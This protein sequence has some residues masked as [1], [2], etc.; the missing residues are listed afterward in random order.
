MSRKKCI[1]Y[2]LICVILIFFTN[3]IQENYFTKRNVSIPFSEINKT[4]TKLNTAC[5][6]P[7][8][9]NI[10][11]HLTDTDSFIIA[12][13]KQNVIIFNSIQIFLL[14]ILA[15]IFIIISR[16]NL[17]YDKEDADI[18][19]LF[20]F[21]FGFLALYKIFY[22]YT[23]NIIN[24]AL[25][26]GIVLISSLCVYFILLG[27][28]NLITKNKTDSVLITIIILTILYNIQLFLTNYPYFNSFEIIG[29]IEILMIAVVLIK[30]KKIIVFL[31]PFTTAIIVL[32]VCNAFFKVI[33]ISN[34]T[35]KHFNQTKE[36]KLSKKPDRDIY[37]ILLDMYAGNDTLQHLGF[38]NTKFLNTLEEKDFLVFDN[39]NSNY[40]KTLPTISSILNFNY[41]DSLHY[42]AP[43]DAIS[44]SELFKIARQLE[45]NIYYLNSWP[46]ELSVNNKFVQHV[47]NSTFYTG[48]TTLAL[49]FANTIFEPVINIFNKTNPVENTLKHINIAINNNKTKKLVFAHFLM[50]HP[51]YLYDENGSIQQN[52]FDTMV[53]NN[54]Y[55][56]NNESYLAFLKYGN[57]ITL[58]LLNQLINT[59]EKQPIIII[60][61]DHGIRQKM[62]TIDEQKYFPELKK[63]EC[64]LKSH[65]NTFLAYYNPDINKEYYKNTNSL[66]NFYR[67][68]A[69]EVFGTEFQ[70]LPDKK[71]YIY[72]DQ[73]PILFDKIKG[74]YVK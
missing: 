69:N 9:L 55:E 39:I 18:S 67:K 51:P 16:K 28:I 61:G 26:G 27:L 48:Q 47:Y 54:L 20:L 1:I 60:F 5:I 31:K 33:S 23:N 25:I 2:A 3:F 44:E 6:T 37:I 62:Y 43:S 52:K 29:I 45:Y 68:F 32:C 24:V 57:N 73:S 58:N 50:P 15:V 34:F 56:Q 71:F 30:T 41:I 7:L 14:C 10:K 72:F 66:V 8:K 22:L 59:K 42:N 49:F 11:S 64:F 36:Y 19:P 65:F 4:C 35:Y 70:T 63:D 13:I 17:K 21:L 12:N 53:R 74:E 38:D 40:N 46:L